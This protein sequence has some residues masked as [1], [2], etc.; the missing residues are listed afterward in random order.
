M[1]N[2]KKMFTI[3]INIAFFRQSTS[4]YKLC[5]THPCAT[6]AHVQELNLSAFYLAEKS[7]LRVS[8]IRTDAGAETRRGLTIRG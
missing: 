4:S 6:S 2:V 3:F 7:V 1:D 5:L 8:A